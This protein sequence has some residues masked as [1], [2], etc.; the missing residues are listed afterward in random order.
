MFDRR[1]EIMGVLEL[2]SPLHVGTGE[3]KEI[4]GVKGRE[5]VNE[6]PEV[7]LIVRD[8]KGRPYLPSTTIKGLL[9]RL[10]ESIEPDHVSDLFGKIK[11]SDAETGNMGAILV[12]GTSLEG[13]AP[14]VSRYPYAEAAGAELGPGVFVAART[15]IDPMSGAA[16]NHKLFFQEMVAPRSRFKL[17]LVLIADRKDGERKR[18]DAVLRILAGLADEQ[19]VVC[20][21]GQADGSGALQL[22]AKSLS[23]VEWAIDPADGALKDKKIDVGLPALDQPEQKPWR[24]IFRCEGPFLSVD[25]SWDPEAAK[26]GDENKKV[27]QLVYQQGADKQPLDLGS[28]IAGVLR[29]RA[30]WLMGL[31]ALARGDDPKS[32]DPSAV[33]ERIAKMPVVKIKGEKDR[34]LRIVRALDDGTEQPLTPVERLFGVSGF[35]GLLA[36]EKMEFSGGEPYDITSVKLDHFSGAPID[37]ALFTTRA[38]IKTRLTLQLALRGRRDTDPEKQTMAAVPSKEDEALFE[39]LWTDMKDNGLMLGHGTGKGFGWFV[40]EKGG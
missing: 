23:I 39:K 11:N 10:C 25:S 6:Q 7:A 14:D 2:L 8:Y 35:A 15:A 17:R 18:L 29:A 24:G 3:V 28:Q 1:Y 12:R 31:E 33:D 16:A 20:G 26:G 34:T 38:V 27:P 4:A 22:L 5:G 36:I 32:V 40:H 37:K 9:R 19:G 13:A 30:R 21:R